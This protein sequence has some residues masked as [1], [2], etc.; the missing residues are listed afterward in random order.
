MD[1]ITILAIGLV[2][3]LDDGPL[4]V[5]RLAVGSVIAAAATA[6]PLTASKSENAFAPSN[7]VKS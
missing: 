3:I 4:R 2:G 1:Q 5:A 6:I 7:S